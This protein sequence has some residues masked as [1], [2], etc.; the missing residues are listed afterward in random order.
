MSPGER[1]QLID[2]LLDG[3]LSESEFKALEATLASDPEARQAYYDR[4][5]LHTALELVTEESPGLEA[6]EPGLHQSTPW[7][8]IMRMA[9]AL[10][11][12]ATVAGL[13]WFSGRQ[14]GFSSAGEARPGMGN[15]DSEPLARGFAVVS[16]QSDAV[17]QEH[18]SLSRGE[19]IP[20]G[21]LTLTSG[22]VQ[23]DLFSGVT[24]IVEGDAS[25]EIVSAMEMRV[26]RGKI[27][28]LV[29]PPAQG[30]RVHTAEGEL[31]D[32]GTE[33][34]IDVQP[35]HADLHVLDGEI[36]WHPA[37]VATTMHSYRRGQAV[38]WAS[39]G[40]VTPL[41]IDPRQSGGISQL[42]AG[43]AEQ[44]RQRRQ[45]WV[46][47]QATW[48]TDP[49]V[50]AYFPMTEEAPG[51][52]RLQGQG[53]HQRQGTLVRTHRAADRWGH[54]GAALDFS[55]T[56]S[57][58]RFEAE[59][60]YQALTLYCWAKIDSLDRWYNSLFLTDG[61]ELHEP[62]WQIMDD[63]RLFFSV[64][65][66]ERR[67]PNNPDKHIC[68]SPP[69]WSSSLSGQWIQIATTYDS[70]TKEV[71]HY[72]NGKA[73]SRETVPD[74]MLV[75]SIKIGAASLGNWSEPKRYDP[76]FAMR[77]LNG[78]IDEFLIFSEALSAEAISDLYHIGKP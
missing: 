27:R 67:G 21:P 6:V 4:L 12:L 43:L 44:R 42:E 9:A 73:I 11:I 19:L 46:A 45:A 76:V 70:A 14:P 61:H 69:F 8:S 49:R 25:F 74:D 41:G 52:R 3:A 78:A 60:T 36:E 65:A 39:G 13:G 54:P 26:D 5:H 53:P 64:K 72:V 7:T 58:V 57:R 77:N 17:W 59:G 40:R 34:A 32:L 20:A 35:G 63:G 50:I 48:E 10:V 37:G 18:G 16:D 23:L 1:D 56:G 71:A 51:H 22:T 68:F 28:A 31:V 33:F 15:S 38:R 55:P 30:F 62:H 47:S 75:N 24:V 66:H 29:P 2:A